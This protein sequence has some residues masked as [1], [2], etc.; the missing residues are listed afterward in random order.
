MK[1]QVRQLVKNALGGAEDNLYRCER[2]CSSRGASE[3]YGQSG[4]TLN[5][6]R[7]GYVN[8]RDELRTCLKW[9]EQQGG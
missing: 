6:I 3:F 9:V 1:T 4:Q 2:A 7:Q 8:R 5:E